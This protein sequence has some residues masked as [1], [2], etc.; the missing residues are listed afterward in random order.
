M[1]CY[2]MLWLYIFFGLDF[3]ADFAFFLLYLSRAC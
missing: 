1:L 3:G 2:A